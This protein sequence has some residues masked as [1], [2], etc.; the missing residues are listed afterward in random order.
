MGYSDQEL[1]NYFGK[2]FEHKSALESPLP[3][4]ATKATHLALSLSLSLVC[5]CCALCV[6]CD[7]SSDGVRV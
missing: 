6:C 4:Y 1:T 3:L 2:H 5:E 7:G